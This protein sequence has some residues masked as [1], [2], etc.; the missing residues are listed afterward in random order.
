MIYLLI[1]W[2]ISGLIIWYILVTS[3]NTWVSKN[4]WTRYSTYL[5]LI[6]LILL[7][8]L[9]FLLLIDEYYW[10]KYLKKIDKCSPK[11]K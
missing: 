5:I 6:C 10:K 7:G 8:P 4:L 11:T 1:L 3:M 9:G 2:P